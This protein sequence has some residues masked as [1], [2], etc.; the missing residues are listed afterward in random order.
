MTLASCSG[1]VVSY[2]R[3]DGKRLWVYDVKA[4]GAAQ[5]FH[6]DM[7]RYGGGLLVASD[8]TEGHIYLFDEESGDVRWKWPSRSGVSS[9]LIVHGGRVVAVTFDD[10]LVSLDARTGEELWRTEA[11][12]GQSDLPVTSSPVVW[13]DDLIFARADGRLSRHQSKS[14]QVLWT[15][16]TGAGASTDLVTFRDHVLC[17]LSD[18]RI[19]G[20]DPANGEIVAETFLEGTP[21]SR[22]FV[23]GDRDL[24]GLTGLEGPGRRLVCVDGSTLELRWTLAAPTDEAWTI[25]QPALAWGHILVGTNSP[26]LYAVDPNTGEIAWR[27]LTDASP[28]TVKV[29]DSDIYIGSFDGTL[30]AYRRVESPGSSEH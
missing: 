18:D 19:I 4:D 1:Q 21:Y 13:D 3:S 24:V 27:A 7:N 17:G 16:E 15:S 14:G 28:R 6:G 23:V 9:D 2:R 29:V 8:A 22:W 30:N 25:A 10:E 20:F 12:E 11:S 26:A 5:S